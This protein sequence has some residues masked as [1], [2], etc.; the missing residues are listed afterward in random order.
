M[1]NRLDVIGE[2]FATLSYGSWTV[3]QY[4]MRLWMT[5][6]SVVLMS[7]I[8]TNVTTWAE[9]IEVENGHSSAIPWDMSKLKLIPT[10]EWGEP[11]SGVSEV[12]YKNEPYNSAP[13][14]VFA[15]YARPEGDGPFPAMVLVHGG[16]GTAFREW[17]ELWAARGYCAIAMDLAGCGPDRVK[18][19]DGG[20]NQD[21][22][23]KFSPFDETD[24]RKM[25][26][27][28][29]IAAVLRGHSLL[30]S[31]PEVDANRIGITGISWGGYLTCIATGIDD[32]L[33]VS[34]PVYGCGFL[35]DESVWQPT[36]ERMTSENRE[37]WLEYFDPSQ[38]L[39]GV[40][41][42][43]LFVNGTDDFAYPLSSHRKSWAVVNDS[44]P[45]L[46]DCAA[47]KVPTNINGGGVI[48][49]PGMADRRLQVHMPHGHQA[50]WALEEI[51]LYVDS[52]L[53]DARPLP[54][55]GRLSVKNNVAR[56]SFENETAVV[57]ASL[58]W[59]TEQGGYVNGRWQVRAW[60]T[61]EAVFDEDGVSV[62]LPEI[63]PLAFF[64]TVTDDRGASTS[65]HYLK[66]NE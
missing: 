23:G 1:N 31:R 33:K 34:V 62:T 42:P 30:A 21:D 64:L 13:T 28:H 22:G 3:F 37:R 20:P 9:L 47:N 11:E 12:Y 24:Y 61:S 63:R 56:A 44:D 49:N 45:T 48:N 38:Y 57:S 14:R 50:G 54:R 15:W 18:L 6:A 35:N 17:A 25:W 32:R 65:T 4:R 16:G 51:G 8:V 19:S 27:Y 29:A 53:K 52:V 39:A 60:E 58:H 40:D 5:Y 36:F 41:C 66:L 26:T 2:L 46:Q 43:M 55:L 10:A 59:T 7:V